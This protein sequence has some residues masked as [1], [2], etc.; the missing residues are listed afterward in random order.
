MYLTDQHV[1]KTY[2]VPKHHTMKTYPVLN[3]APCHEDVSST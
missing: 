2:P 1:M 3:W